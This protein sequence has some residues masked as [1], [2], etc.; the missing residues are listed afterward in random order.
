MYIFVIAILNWK[1]E[2]SMNLGKDLSEYN[3]YVHIL[4]LIKKK[5]YYISF[6][7]VR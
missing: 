1:K 3:W 5:K 6:I 7:E 2:I 4:I